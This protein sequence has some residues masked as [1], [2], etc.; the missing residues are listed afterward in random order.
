MSA[1]NPYFECFLS[2][3]EVYV[4]SHKYS[5]NEMIL[6]NGCEQTREVVGWLN[7]D[8]QIIGGFWG[9]HQWM[10]MLNKENIVWNDG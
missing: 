4:L 10:L 1:L 3:L 9:V 6:Q 7:F 5:K 2:A 8:N